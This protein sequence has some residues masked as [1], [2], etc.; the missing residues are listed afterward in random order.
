MNDA[1][2]AFMPIRILSIFVPEK[3]RF[4]ETLIL[5]QF[6]YLPIPQKYSLFYESA[7]CSGL[8]T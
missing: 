6:F 7:D 3:S 8:I 4:K 5:S 1:A 2:G